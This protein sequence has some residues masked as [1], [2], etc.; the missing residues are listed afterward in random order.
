MGLDIVFYEKI[1]RVDCVFDAG[2]DAI[3]P[4]TRRPLSMNDK[5]KAF[6]QADMTQFAEGITSGD[7]YRTRGGGSFYAGGYMGFM[8]FRDQLA[9]LSGWTRSAEGGK[10]D[11]IGPYWHS[12]FSKDGGPFWE[13]LVFSDCEGTIGHKTSKKLATDFD[14][15]AGDAA[16][17]VVDP[18]TRDD[19][20]EYF[21]KTYSN[22]RRAFEIAAK[23]GAVVFC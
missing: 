2:G 22:F 6:V 20:T 12:A 18:G 16:V 9:K 14:K 19:F 7:V 17:F 10:Y 3:S 5:F 13:L 11:A 8:W 4:K 23:G 1:T 15:H 21:R